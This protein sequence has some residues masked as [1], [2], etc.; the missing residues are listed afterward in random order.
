MMH[1]PINIRFVV[2]LFVRL[3]CVSY[4]WFMVMHYKFNLSMYVQETLVIGRR[5]CMGRYLNEETLAADNSL[6]RKSVTYKS[7]VR[8]YS[9]CVSL[10]KYDLVV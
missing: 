4:G 6:V 1:G 3:V 5:G 7:N 10:K 8:E 9:D 2:H